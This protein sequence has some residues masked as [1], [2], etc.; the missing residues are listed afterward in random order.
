MKFVKTQVN[1]ETDKYFLGT[2][3]EQVTLLASAPT[4]EPADSHRSNRTL[5]TTRGNK[6]LTGFYK[7]THG[8]TNIQIHYAEHRLHRF[9]ESC[10]R[11]GFHYTTA[12]NPSG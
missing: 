9:N 3:K 11:H 5:H 7:Q 10:W 2:S 8:G 4:R 12:G 6:M 1:I